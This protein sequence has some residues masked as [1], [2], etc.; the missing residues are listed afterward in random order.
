MEETNIPTKLPRPLVTAV[1]VIEDQGRENAVYREL[2]T[3]HRGP[4][5]HAACAN[6]EKGLFEPPR[7]E[8]NAPVPI[9]AARDPD[10]W[11]DP[12]RVDLLGFSFPPLPSSLV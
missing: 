5:P 12:G 2:K 11:I 4:C 3:E 8:A 9:G 1:D 6:A 10:V 7:P